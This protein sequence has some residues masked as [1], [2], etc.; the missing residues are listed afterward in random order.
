MLSRDENELLT[1]TGPGAPMGRLMRRY[2]TNFLM[3][4][5]GHV[6]AKSNRVHY[7]APIDD[8]HCWNYSFTFG[9]NGKHV[10]EEE[11]RSLIADTGPD[12]RKLRNLGND[13]LQDR[14]VQRSGTFTGIEGFLAQDSCVTESMGPVCDRTSDHLS[15]SDVPIIAVRKFL[16][17]ALRDLEEGK[18]PPCLIRDPEKVFRRCVSTGAMLPSGASWRRL[19]EEGR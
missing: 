9:A 1:R 15:K 19:L 16:L 13:Y 6:S 17:R 11:K 5:V 12:Y 10:E 2:W 3:P 8:T 7:W 14:Q 4:S 18:E